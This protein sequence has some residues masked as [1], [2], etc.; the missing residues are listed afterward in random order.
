MANNS[1]TNRKRLFGVGMALALLFMAGFWQ[2]NLPAGYASPA[3]KGPVFDIIPDASPIPN[4]ATSG[5]FVLTGKVYPFRSVNPAT[6]ALFP[7]VDPVKDQIGTWTATV[8]VTPAIPSINT[9]S[10]TGSAA[11]RFQMHQTIVL[12]S[13]P[14]II[15]VHGLNGLFALDSSVTAIDPSSATS[16]TTGPTEIQTITGGSFRFE[17]LNGSAGIR[18][19]CGGALST[20]ANPLP[21]FRFDRAFCIGVSQALPE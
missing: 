11:N 1:R 14:G 5:T 17:G 13:L 15:E 4:G 20:L 8:V 6:C 21:P 7:N 3:K 16:A 19:Y 2:I 10:A 9:L 12:E 18:P